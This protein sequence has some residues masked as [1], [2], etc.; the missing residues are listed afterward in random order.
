MLPK[1][2]KKKYR[3]AERAWERPSRGL[4]RA[5]IA[6]KIELSRKSVLQI[7]RIRTRL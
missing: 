6:S 5:H 7:N 3:A 2:R 1:P 4:G